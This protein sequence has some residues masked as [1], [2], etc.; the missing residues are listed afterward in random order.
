M[1]KAVVFGSSGMVG[2]EAIKYLLKNK[3]ISEVTSISRKPLNIKN[4]KL[5]EII[6]NDF[7]DLSSLK[8]ELS[9]QNIC[10]YCIGVYTGAVSED[11]FKI[12]SVDYI[13]VLA[14]TLKEVNPNIAISYLSGAGADR[15]AKTKI[16]FAKYK[17]MAESILLESGFGQVMIARPNYIHPQ[18][19]RV[20]PNMMYKV[21]NFIYGLSN[22]KYG[23]SFINSDL[24]AQIMVDALLE[25]SKLTTFEHK[26]L[27]NFIKNKE[28]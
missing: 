9:K 16:I 5:K 8:S 23:I 7:M 3:Q 4:S 28:K 13:K 2:G 6:H 19:P 17:G 27:I 11:I 18:S 15:S 24:L 1:V 14:D 12:I 20:A 10:I 22:K 26:D 25:K 21:L